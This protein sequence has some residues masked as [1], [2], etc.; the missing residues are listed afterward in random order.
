M[1]ADG[2]MSGRKPILHHTLPYY[3]NLLEYRH[4][5]DTTDAGQTQSD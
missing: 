5:T 1:A 4:D 3:N 2:P